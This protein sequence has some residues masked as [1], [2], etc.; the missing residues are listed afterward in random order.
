VVDACRTRTHRGTKYHMT[1]EVIRFV[2]KYI[3]IF[4]IMYLFRRT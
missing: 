1:S 3:N 2:T 4:F